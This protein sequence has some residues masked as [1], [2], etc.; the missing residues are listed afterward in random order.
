MKTRRMW[1]VGDTNQQ[2]QWIWTEDTDG[3]VSEGL[4]GCR[5]P[6]SKYVQTGDPSLVCREANAEGPRP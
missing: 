1:V 4:R 6:S 5:Q 2:C 3:S